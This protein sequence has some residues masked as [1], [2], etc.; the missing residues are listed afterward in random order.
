VRTF[1]FLA[2]APGVLSAKS[3]D[4]A[5]LQR[6]LGTPLFEFGWIPEFRN[7]GTT[8]HESPGRGQPGRRGAAAAYTTAWGRSGT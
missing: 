6:R 8:R 3:T 5:I 2:G 7:T 4:A 1:V